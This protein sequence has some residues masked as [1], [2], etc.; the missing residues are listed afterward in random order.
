M[1]PQDISV[2]KLDRLVNNI[3]ADNFISFSEDEILPGGN[4]S[5]K[6]LHITTRCKMTILHKVLIDNGSALNVMPWSTLSHLL[7]NASLIKQSH[8]IVRALIEGTSKDL[9]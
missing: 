3:I 6:A 4:N 9:F 2:N 5:P 7:V 8:A 1:V